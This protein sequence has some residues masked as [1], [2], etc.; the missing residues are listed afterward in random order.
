MSKKGLTYHDHFPEDIF[1]EHVLSATLDKE[2]CI[3]YKFAEGVEFGAA[4]NY[5]KY[6]RMFEKEK[7]KI[8]MKE[9]LGSEEVLRVKEYCKEPRQPKKIREFLGIKGETSYRKRIQEP[10]C[11]AGKLVADREKPVN[12]RLYTWVD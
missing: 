10:L 2:G 3:K 4:L 8:Q 11:K 5:K 1:K 12:Q 7:R 9:L 6:K